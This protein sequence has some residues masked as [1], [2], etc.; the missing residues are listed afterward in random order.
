MKP[1]LFVWGMNMKKILE[2][3]IKFKTDKNIE[4][5]HQCICYIAN[6]LDE[7]QCVYEIIRNDDGKENIVALIGRNDFYRLENAILLSGHLDVVGASDEMFVPSLKNGRVFG[8]GTV[9]MKSFIAVVLSSIVE[10]KKINKPIVLAISSDEETDVKGVKNI[11]K[12]FDKNEIKF[13]GGIVGEP[14]NFGIGV[15]NRGYLSGKFEIRGK[16]VH[17]SINRDGINV[18]EIMGKLWKKIFELND[19]YYDEGVT[20]N[21]GNIEC[22][23]D[24]NVIADLGKFEFEIRYKNEEQK[25][26]ILSDI[27]DEAEKLKKDYD[28]SIL[29]Y[30]LNLE[31]PSFVEDKCCDFV[32]KNMKNNDYEIKRLAYATEAGFYQN[33]GIDVVIFGVGDEKLCHTESESVL[34]DDLFKYKEM[35]LNWLK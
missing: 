20:L 27:L 14:T 16:A 19:K 18:I 8:R 11:L 30:N 12:F 32:K 2:D 5:I 7:H 28:G 23:N 22:I 25:N 34:I 4:E 24:V 21:V 31:I 9:D 6:I 13:E 1:P 33:Y 26:M 10:L 35:L 17:S 15:S 3:L 29:M